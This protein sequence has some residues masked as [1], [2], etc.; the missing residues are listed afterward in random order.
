MADREIGDAAVDVDI[1]IDRGKPFAR[2]VAHRRVVEKSIADDFMAEEQIGRDVE[3]RYEI[4]LLVDRGDSGGLRFA[5][6]AERDGL[7]VDLNLSLV[8]Q[9]RARQDVHQR[10]LARAVLAEQRM[11]LAGIEREIDAAQRPRAA[12][13]LGDSARRQNG[14]AA[15][16]FGMRVHDGGPQELR[17]IRVPSS[18]MVRRAPS[19]WAMRSMRSAAAWRPISSQGWAT[20][21]SRGSK[22]SAHSKS[23]M[24]A[25]EMSS[26]AFTPTALSAR[27]A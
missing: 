9:M 23:S 26:G 10:R 24:P 2:L 21:V 25:I 17:L 27:M 6:I 22:Q 19:A 14:R 15:V 13:T 12:K 4:E 7:A 18:R 5:R 11:D 16:G 1:E 8:R 3:A 20:T